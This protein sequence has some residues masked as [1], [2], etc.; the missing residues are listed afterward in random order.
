MVWLRRILDMALV[1]QVSIEFLGSQIR[2]IN[3]D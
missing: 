3:A 1:E 2:G